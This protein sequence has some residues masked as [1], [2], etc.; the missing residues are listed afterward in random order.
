[1]ADCVVSWVIVLKQDV[2]FVLST[3][4]AEPSSMNDTV[5]TLGSAVMASEI[6]LFLSI[7]NNAPYPETE[8]ET[9][10]A[11]LAQ[12]EL[13]S[14][15]TKLGLHQKS[16]AR[17]VRVKIRSGSETREKTNSEHGKN[18]IILITCI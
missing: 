4:K 11:A 13:G 7:S 18:K 10:I 5:M 12:L 17:G 6:D 3:K 15:S 1:L 9:S 2:R 16:Q 14:D 8:T